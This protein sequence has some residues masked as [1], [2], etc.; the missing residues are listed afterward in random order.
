MKASAGKRVLMLIENSTYPLDVRVR[1]EATTLTEAGYLVS[2]ICQRGPNEPWRENIENVFVYRY[3][4]PPQAQGFLGYIV[5]YSYSFV[6]T[7]VMSL[8]VWAL[9]GFD[10]IHAANPPDTAVFVAMFY[11]L[12]G[13]KFVFD[14]HDLAPEMYIV[15]SRNGSNRMVHRILVWLEKTSFRVADHVIATNQSYK[16]VA[17]QRGSVPE[18]RITVVR[19]GPALDRLRLVQP[20]PD[21]RKRGAVIIGY[22]GVMGPQDGIDYLLRAL[23]QLI[24]TLGRRDYFCI[25]IGKG[26]ALDD[27]KVL[28]SHLELDQNVWFTGFIPEVD[29]LRYMSTVDICVDPDPSNI[30]NDRCTMIK[31]MEYM[32]LGKPIVAFDLPEHRVTAAE[33]A[34]YAY[35]NDELDF[36]RQILVLMDD[37]ELRRNLGQI[38]RERVENELAWPYQSIHLLDAYKSLGT[39]HNQGRRPRA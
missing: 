3:P 22:I 5:E 18:R 6:V 13:K 28:A 14:H 26:S 21:L 24:T 23:K 29:M 30:F 15:R 25:I 32:T 8:I 20:D 9:R 36:A 4:A 37:P 19:N 11:K 35:P 33:A 27:L 34:L 38:G 12:Y 2:V 17:M 16:N 7:F 39:D 31:M 1:Y 10:I